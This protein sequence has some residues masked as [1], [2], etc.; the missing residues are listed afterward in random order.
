MKCDNPSHP[1]YHGREC[2]CADCRLL[3]TCVSNTDGEA[4]GCFA[5]QGPVTECDAPLPSFSRGRKKN[6]KIRQKMSNMPGKI[7]VKNALGKEIE[8][9]TD[10]SWHRN[11]WD[12]KNI[13]K[14]CCHCS[15][16]VRKEDTFRVIQILALT[17]GRRRWLPPPGEKVEGICL[18]G[19]CK[20]FII[21]GRKLRKCEY[22]RKPSLL[23][24]YHR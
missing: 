2:L 15:H 16:C 9:S 22:F 18:W 14:D 13:T 19:V 6:R 5:C 4:D 7:M 3:N 20:K 8:I 10:W 21:Q 23:K 24:T 1:E 17:K 11:D 12:S